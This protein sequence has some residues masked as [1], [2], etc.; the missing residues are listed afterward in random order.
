MREI[1]DETR[2]DGHRVVGAKGYT[3]Y[4]VAMCAAI[5]C[6]AIAGDARTILPVSTLI[7]G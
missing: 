2:V 7:E 4:T 1:V 6:E 5:I 3:N